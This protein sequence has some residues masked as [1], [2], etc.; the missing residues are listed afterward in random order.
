MA[1]YTV[2][3]ARAPLYRRSV[4]IRNLG[5]HFG[6]IGVRQLGKPF[7]QQDPAGVV[8][9]AR[10]NHRT[11]TA[12]RLASSA[13]CAS[14]LSSR[15]FQPFDSPRISKLFRSFG[16]PR[17]R[18]GS[19]FGSVAGHRKAHLDLLDLDL[20]GARRCRFL[21]LR[22]ARFRCGLLLATALRFCGRLSGFASFRF[23]NPCSFSLKAWAKIEPLCHKSY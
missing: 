15:I 11:R 18:R 8:L 6:L 5:D 3:S 1:A 14:A 12:L 17:H 19:F 10:M 4:P 13:R 21:L 7:V 20:L 16:A 2:S 9:G 23:S 22:L